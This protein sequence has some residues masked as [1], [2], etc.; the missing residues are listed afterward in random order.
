MNKLLGK[1]IK[2]CASP[3]S[4]FF[5]LS[6]FLTF[7]PGYPVLMGAFF[8]TLGIFYSFQTT[9]ENSDITYSFLLPLSKADIVKG[10][11][12]FS[13]FIETLS[14]ALMTAVTLIRMIFLSTAPVY[15]SNALMGANFVSLGF[16]LLIFALFN[17][18]FI[19]GFFKTAYYFGKPFLIYGICSAATVCLAETLYHIPPLKVLNSLGFQNMAVQIF[20]LILG[21][22]LFALLTFLGFKYSVKRFLKVD[23]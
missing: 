20:A 12:L 3:L 6:A 18:I 17:L 23:L 21:I 5:I 22:I 13:V 2:L 14:F 11:F 16:S 4:F 10:K 7:L 15:K 8:T 9:R 1:E 19:G